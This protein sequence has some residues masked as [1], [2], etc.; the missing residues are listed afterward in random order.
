MAIGKECNHPDDCLRVHPM[1]FKEPE[2]EGN[3]PEIIPPNSL[4]RMPCPPGE[5]RW[6]PTEK[7]EP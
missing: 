1:E 7:A 2:D 5:G 3:G 4:A 6:N